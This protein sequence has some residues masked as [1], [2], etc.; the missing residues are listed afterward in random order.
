MDL[1][2]PA[3]EQYVVETSLSAITTSVLKNT[4]TPA[5]ILEKNSRRWTRRT[6][7][8]CF[9]PVY[10]FLKRFTLI[11]S[12]L[13]GIDFMMQRGDF[14]AER[15]EWLSVFSFIMQRNDWNDSR[16]LP[17]EAKQVSVLLGPYW[18]VWLDTN[19]LKFPIT[20]VGKFQHFTRYG[21]SYNLP[22]I[23]I[24][25]LFWGAREERFID[26]FE[27]RSC[28]SL[29]RHPSTNNWQAYKNVSAQLINAYWQYFH[30]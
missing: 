3:A 17:S 2:G 5:G 4:K 15:P 7:I 22:M 21:L 8:N 9:F 24:I 1:K 18:F 25:V 30:K 11:T 14:E 13:Q 26:V 27:G 29:W 6:G 28:W 20:C 10:V 12:H 19:Y 16:N 23:C